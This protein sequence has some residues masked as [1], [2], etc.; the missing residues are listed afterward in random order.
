M[1]RKEL[2]HIRRF[3]LK[4]SMQLGTEGLH[5][6]PYDYNVCLL[7]NIK[8][9]HLQVP[10]LLGMRSLGSLRTLLAAE[11]FC[12]ILHKDLISNHANGLLHVELCGV[13]RLLDIQSTLLYIL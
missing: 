8:S 5:D 3:D 9:G 10:F 2:K 1:G 4:N 12:C 13:Y 11:V 7:E 6:L